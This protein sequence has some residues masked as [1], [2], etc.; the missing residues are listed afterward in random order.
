MEDDSRSKIAPNM[1]NEQNQLRSYFMSPASFK[2]DSQGFAS[3][4]PVCLCTPP[5]CSILA[6]AGLAN[7]FH[8]S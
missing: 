5:P 4:F 1:G 2:P 3:F 7:I 8:L 6:Y